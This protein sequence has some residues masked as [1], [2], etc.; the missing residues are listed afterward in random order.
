MKSLGQIFDELEWVAVWEQ[1]QRLYEIPAEGE[2]AY[3]SAFDEVRGMAPVVSSLKIEIK[4]Y[5]PDSDESGGSRFGVSGIDEDGSGDISFVPWS[6]WKGM[7][8]DSETDEQYSDDEVVAHCLEEMTFAGFSQE[9]VQKKV[10]ELSSRYDEM[11]K[12]SWKYLFQ[13]RYLEL[14][15]LFSDKPLPIWKRFCLKLKEIGQDIQA[16][17]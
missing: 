15:E 17:L 1:L 6:N 12:W 13:R 14:D 5:D 11:R 7:E 9:E 2:A 3:K 16:V 8:I 4:E 10:A